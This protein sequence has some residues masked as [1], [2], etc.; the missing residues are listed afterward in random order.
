MHEPTIIVGQEA[1]LHYIIQ[2]N[3]QI[4]AELKQ[5]RSK[6][7]MLTQD[8]QTAF[9]NLNS[10]V[11]KLVTDFGTYQSANDTAMKA[12][13]DLIAALQK[14]VADLGGQAAAKDKTIADLQAADQ[15]A[16]ADVATAANAATATI[17]TLDQ[18]IVALGGTPVATPPANPPAAPTGLTATP[19]DGRVNL[20]WT[21][22]DNTT[23]GYDV[24]RGTTTGGPYTSLAPQ[25]PVQGTT[26]SDTAV[27]NGTTYF[28]VVV[29]MGPGGKSAP[30]NEASATPQAATPPPAGGGAT[31]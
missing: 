16:S 15:Q 4:L 18:H 14:Q 5:V 13:D 21:A 17:G 1:A 10:G 11:G 6:L 28:Y 8:E 30:S 23:T 29:A 3:A 25:A 20:S 22:G 24:Q 12:K 26:D 2:Q 9:N 19:G 7:T 31:P 27:T